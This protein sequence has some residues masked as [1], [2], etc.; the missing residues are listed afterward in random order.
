MADCARMRRWHAPLGR[1]ACTSLR[2]PHLASPRSL[3]PPHD[4]PELVANQPASEV[5][6]V[7]FPGPVE[8]GKREPAAQLIVSP[9]GV[10]NPPPNSCHEPRVQ[11][12]HVMRRALSGADLNS[13][14]A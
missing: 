7:Q 3:E 13:I 8:I 2:P 9:T 14:G 5:V 1:A 6:R 11:V 12:E 4:P 10:L